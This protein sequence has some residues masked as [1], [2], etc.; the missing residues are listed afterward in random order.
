MYVVVDQSVTNEAVR[1]ST[2]P[3]TAAGTIGRAT[4]MAPETGAVAFLAA[5]LEVN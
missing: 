2:R 5:C 4:A 3:T 1:A